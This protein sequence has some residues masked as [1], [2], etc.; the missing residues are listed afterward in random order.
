MFRWTKYGNGI[1]DSTDRSRLFPCENV[2]QHGVIACLKTLVYLMK[3]AQRLA[4]GINCFLDDRALCKGVIA[5]HTQNKVRRVRR[6]ARKLLADI[7][8]HTSIEG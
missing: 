4:N 5:A 7:F 3:E 6:H 1:V 2:F 8:R